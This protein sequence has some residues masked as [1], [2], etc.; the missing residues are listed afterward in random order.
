LSHHFLNSL[1]AI[2]KAFGILLLLVLIIVTGLIISAFLFKDRIIQQFINEAN[3]SINTPVKISRIE[4]SAWNDFPNM[5][6]EF[7]DVYVEDS[8]PGLYPL[9]TAKTIS[10]SLNAFEVWKGNYSVRG[11]KVT[12]SETNLKIDATG[13]SNYAI[14]KKEDNGG[15]AIQFDLRG[16]KLTNTQV[17]YSDQQI[18]HQHVFTSQTLTSS[19]KAEN[20]IYHIEAD[21]DITTE[22]IGINGKLFLKK[23]EFDTRIKLDYDDVGKKVIIKPSLLT[24]NHSSFDIKGTYGFK[25]KNEIDLSTE[26]KD[27]NIQTILSLFPEEVSKDLRHYK[28][29]GNV[30]FK[31]SLKGEISERKSPF[32]SVS[33][34]CNDATIHHPEYKSKIT[35]ANLEGSFASPSV[36]DFEKAELFLKN[37]QG[38]LNDKRFEAN[39]SILNFTNP[40]IDFNF[41]GNVDISSI[42]NFYPFP[43]FNNPTGNIQADIS[44]IGEIGLLKKKTTAQRVKTNGSIKLEDVS[45]SYDNQKVPFENLN[46]TLQFNNNDLALSGVNGKLGNSDFI[47]NGFFKN[48]ITYLL[49]DNQPIG[50]ETDLKSDFIDLDQLFEIGFGQSDTNSTEFSISPNIHLNFNCN[51]KKMN[52]K[53]FNLRKIK[54]DLLVRNQMA[55]SRNTSFDA[56]GGHLSLNGIIDA[57]QPKAIDVVSMFK[58][59]GVY[60]DS[61]FYSFENFRQN[62]IESKHL[63]GQAFADVSLEMIF[64]Q[65]LDMLPESLIA[66]ISATIKNGELNNFEPMK[67]LSKYLDEEGLSKLRFA[68]LKN[69]IHIENKTIYIPQMEIKNNLTTIQLSGTHTFDQHINYRVVAPLQNKKKIDPDEAFGAIE[70][71]NRGKMKVFLKITGTTDQYEVSLDKQAVKKQVA[72][73]FKKE[74]Q[75]LKD[76]FKLKGKKKQKELELE[77]DDYFDW[78]EN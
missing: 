5:A 72:G 27:T 44:L 65:N 58:L 10:F 61:I 18:H 7:H 75:E 78:K 3:K 13:K 15:S 20:N 57:H 32:I 21:G 71:D 6:I 1:K 37:I 74:V 19:I 12:D 48:I 39:L 22:Q 16:I 35:H 56:L 42:R 52:Y 47:L 66:D 28:S 70:Q 38:E 34:G 41:K 9:F 53:R 17:S 24:I 62:F 73:E 59:N 45:F 46:G 50:I 36:T 54:G 49:F 67:S 64:N 30:F 11:L 25:N 4:F 26:G 69:D 23:K 68:D 14:T 43:Q 8:H 63:K 31:L 2:R 60:V 55:V 76:A 51:I 77:K 33:F 40:S 29:D